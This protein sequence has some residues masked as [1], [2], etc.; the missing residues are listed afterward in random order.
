[1]S[2]PANTTRLP[3]VQV[4]SVPPATWAEMARDCNLALT[5][6]EYGSPTGALSDALRDRLRGYITDHLAEPA[7]QYAASLTDAHRRANAEASVQSALGV[8]ATQGGDPQALLRLLGKAAGLLM[9][10]AGVPR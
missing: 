10:Y 7:R 8:A 9:R 2:Q 4:K 1:M 5:L 6:A 3:L